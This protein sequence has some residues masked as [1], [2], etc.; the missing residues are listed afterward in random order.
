MQILPVTMQETV[1]GELHWQS[2]N[3]S[4]ST[5]LLNSVSSMLGRGLYFNQHKNIFSS[6]C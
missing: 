2:P 5:P 4:A 3:V 6:C 1:Y